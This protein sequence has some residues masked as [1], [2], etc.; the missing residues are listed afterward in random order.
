M[1]DNHYENVHSIENNQNV[2][3]D[4]NVNKLVDLQEPSESNSTFNQT[5]FHAQINDILNED[6][7]DSHAVDPSLY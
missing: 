6:D 3:L 7:D 4:E 1:S 5:N 2:Y